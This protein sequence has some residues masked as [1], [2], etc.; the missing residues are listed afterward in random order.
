MPK[1][2]NPNPKRRKVV[3]YCD[4]PNAKKVALVGTFNDWDPSRH[5]MNHGGGGRWNKTLLL[6]AG[7]YEYKF[8]IDGLWQ[9]DPR[10][11]Q[12]VP[13]PFGTRNSQLR[14]VAK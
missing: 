13:N 9:E 4:A 14:V 5:L 2:S 6:S 10:N 12:T 11:R 1:L 8:W 3:F 7:E